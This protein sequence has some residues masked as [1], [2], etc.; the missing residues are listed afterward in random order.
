LAPRSCEN[1]QP[2]DALDQLAL[3]EEV[4][5][6]GKHMQLDA[7]TRRAHQTLDDHLVLVALVL[8]EQGFLGGID[9]ARDPVAA[10]DVAPD[11]M[12]VLARI[13]LARGSSRRRNTRRPRPPHAGAK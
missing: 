2:L 11:E 4:G 1:A 12:R 6:S 10:V 3:L 5:R 8:Q 13:E 9:E 7:A